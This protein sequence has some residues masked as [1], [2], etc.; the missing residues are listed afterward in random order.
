M[1]L[2]Y[3]VWIKELWKFLIYCFIVNICKVK[4]KIDIF[5]VLLLT[6]KA[7]VHLDGLATARIKNA[8]ERKGIF[9]LLHSSLVRSKMIE[10]FLIR[11]RNCL[12][13]IT[14]RVETQIHK[15]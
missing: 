2:T 14:L 6:Y 10:K 4:A 9:D 5:R 13:E 12:V 3:F 1:N 8:I 7:S 11:Q 15:Q